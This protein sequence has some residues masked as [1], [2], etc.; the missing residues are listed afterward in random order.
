MFLSEGTLV[1]NGYVERAPLKI[2]NSENSMFP[3]AHQVHLTYKTMAIR[4][5]EDLLQSFNVSFC[6]GSG[7]LFDKKSFIPGSPSSCSVMSFTKHLFG[8]NKA[9]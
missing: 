1:K 7:T 4:N 3:L 9:L 5:I 8:N 2:C 6:A